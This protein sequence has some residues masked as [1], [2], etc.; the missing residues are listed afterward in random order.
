MKY[1]RVKIGYG[2]NDFIS[3]DETEL[4]KALRAQIKGTVAVFN[5]GSIAGNSIISILPDYQRVMDWNRDHQLS[6]EDYEYIGKTRQDEY[7]NLIEKTKIEVNRQLGSGESRQIQP[8]ISE[9]TKQLADK[10][11]I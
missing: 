10:F 4:A 5:E 2:A 7:R 3:I 8:Q 9:Q 1:F 6:G 11:R